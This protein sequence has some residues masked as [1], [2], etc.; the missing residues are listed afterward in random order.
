MNK[1][2]Y[3]I[4]IISAFSCNLLWGFLPLYWNALKPIESSVIIF[5]RIVLMAIICY[6]VTAFTMRGRNV[7]QPMVESRKSFFTYISAGVVITINWSIYIWAV[8][9]GYVIQTSMGYFLEPLIVCL[10]GIIFY[11]EKTNKWKKTAICFAFAGMLVMIIGYREIPLIAVSLGLTFAIYSAIKKS[12]SIHPLQ[13]LLFETI[14]IAPFALAVIVYM[15]AKGTGGLQVGGYHYALLMF[16]GLC[17]AVPLGLFSYAANKISL[18]TIGICEYISPSI[19][20]ILGIFVMNEPFD[21]IQ[22]AAFA[23]IWI[24]LAFFTYGE[25]VEYC[26]MIKK[27]EA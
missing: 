23:V 18:V 25:R 6:A 22:L 14:A 12:I 1:N 5:Y 2:E 7:F 10:F 17:T 9:A 20:L 13:S 26:E 19:S 15:E 24:G 16:A 11:K 27:Q 4:G 21:I 8:N 3:K